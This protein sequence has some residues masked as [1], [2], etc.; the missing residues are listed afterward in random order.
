[1]LSNVV[2]FPFLHLRLDDFANPDV[3]WFHENRYELDAKF[4]I[5]SAFTLS[6]SSKAQRSATQAWS[7]ACFVVLLFFASFPGTAEPRVLALFAYFGARAAY[8]GFAEPPERLGKAVWAL[9]CVAVPLNISGFAAPL[10]LFSSPGIWF[11][12]TA[13]FLVAWQDVVWFRTTLLWP[14]VVWCAAW[15]ACETVLA[16]VLYGTH[17]ALLILSAVL[18]LVVYGCVNAFDRYKTFDCS[19]FLLLPPPPPPPP[20]VEAE[21]EEEKE[22]G[23]KGSIHQV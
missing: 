23:G 15:I 4:D 7:V 19:V 12:R 14:H 8:A 18:T 20:P 22:E 16:S 2:S 21:G 9:H 3:F 13:A 5:H 10:L 17:L 11:T 1:M 6:L